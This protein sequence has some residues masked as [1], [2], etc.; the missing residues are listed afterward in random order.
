[1]TDELNQRKTP[2]TDTSQ[3]ADNPVDE[4]ARIM[5]YNNDPVPHVD[6][7]MAGTDPATDLEAELMREFGIDT[8]GQQSA[9]SPAPEDVDIPQDSPSDVV[10]SA[11]TYAPEQEMPEQVAPAMPLD[12][13]E[14]MRQ[15]IEQPNFQP[16]NS[17]LTGASDDVLAE[18]AQYNVPNSVEA[19]SASIIP[20]VEN[21]IQPSGDNFA[22]GLEQELAKL[23]QGLSGGLSGDLETNEVA[24]E[25]PIAPEVSIH[26]PVEVPVTPLFETSAPSAPELEDVVDMSAL[27]E[28]D[29]DIEH[30]TEFDIPSVEPIAV[31]A[32][33][34]P[35]FDVDLD[36]E[37]ER[38]FSQMFSEEK[39]VE[40][41]PVPEPAQPSEPI[42]LA[43]QNVASFF[44]LTAMNEDQ[45][46]T[47]PEM[48]V[49]PVLLHPERID[50]SQDKIVQ[51]DMPD[52]QISDGSS[53]GKFAAVGVFALLILG[54]GGYF[55][56][57]N[58]ASQDA[59]SGEPVIIKADNSPI[60]EEP[61]DPGGTSVPN[62]DLAVYNQVEGNDTSI[63]N[64]PSLVEATEEPVDIV[65]NTLDPTLL[66][67][68]GRG[69]DEKAEDRLVSADQ[70][71][72]A[73]AS[74]NAQPL[75]VPRKVRTVVVQADGTIITREE[76][77]A[78]EQ[79]A[80]VVP[81]VVEQASGNQLD[82]AT[83]DTSTATQLQQAVPAATNT[84]Q[85]ATPTPAPS[86][87]Q[88][89]AVEPS[90]PVVAPVEV[91]PQAATTSTA[92][93]VANYSGYYMQ[94]ASQPSLAAAQSSYQTLVGRYN[95][96]LG[97]RGVEYQRADIAG[98]GTFHRVRI[99]AGS[100]SEA[101]SLC[102]RYKSAG[103]SCFVAR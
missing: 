66:P 56:Y 93:P 79:P 19:A 34:E 42:P 92:A 57:N 30:T 32:A 71:N 83:L 49:A 75:I 88:V 89:A 82:N 35:T 69:L 15:P 68:E 102:S 100:R 12:Q 94:I 63:A 36:S 8:V 80:P 44:D 54:V 70:T 45:A 61:D 85:S 28:T 81:Q 90:P 11:Q 53:T 96:V 87:T 91:A 64:Q 10:A 25:Q 84:Q 78:V 6:Q 99:Q 74:G 65:Q 1:M 40:E 52:A 67:L 98:K 62:Q 55:V 2:E 20:A 50:V 38:E 16:E 72:V 76:P 47:S 46:Q 41:L 24:T 48:G 77:A 29:N 33:S 86:D 73:V 60:K 18:M 58:I 27:H 101:N 7:A 14:F 5:G 9:T 4:L 22:N 13:A 51:Q 39:P 95:S 17:Q 59:G 43:D 103:G 37:L 23:Q 21:T 26:E 97:N 3:V 31:A